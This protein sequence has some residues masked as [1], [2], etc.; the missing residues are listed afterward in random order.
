MRRIISLL[1]SLL[2]FISVY[3]QKTSTI[4]GVVKD[5]TTGEPLIGASVSYDVGKGTITELD[6][7]YKLTLDTGVYTF[8]ISFIGYVETTAKVKANRNT[9]V[10]DFTLDIKPMKEVEIVGDVAKI[11][12]TPVAFANVNAQQIKEELG[13]RDLPMLL[14]S[15]PGVYATQT[16]GGKG[17][18]RINIRGFDQKN[19]AVMV[20]GVPVNDMENGSVFWSNWEG[21]GDVTRSMQVQRGLGA[22]KLAIPSVGGTI[23]II[24]KGIES[25]PGGSI[26]QEVGSFGF[27]KTSF[28]YTTGLINKK[29]GVTVAGSH[30]TGNGYVD[31]TNFTTWSYFVKVQYIAGKHLLS[32]GGNGSPQQHQQRSFSQPMPVFDKAYAK[33]FGIDTDSSLKA[34]GFSNANHDDRGLK[35]NPFWGTLT[36]DGKTENLNEKV[37]FYHKPQ[38]SFSDNWTINDKLT[39][40]NIAYLSIGNGGGTQLFNT[41]ITRAPETGQYNLQQV[42]DNQISDKAIDKFYSSTFHK[43]SNI[44]LASNNDHKWYGLLSNIQYKMNDNFTFTGGLDVRNYQGSHY[45]TVYDLLGG[46]YFIDQ[47]NNSQPKILA[48]VAPST[49][50]RNAAYSMKTTWDKIAYYNDGLVRWFGL[51]TQAEY[52]RNNF[53][54]FVTVT[55]SETQYKRVDYF[56][57]KD[58]I[59]NGKKISQ[60]VGWGDT[61]L[62][63]GTRS[64]T[65]N[66]NNNS[67]LKKKGDTTFL[68]TKYVVNP[69]SYTMNST[70]ANTS[71]TNWRTFF[72]YTIKTGANYNFNSHFNAFLNLGY[73]SMAPR[74][75]NV[76]DNNN[77]EFFETKNQ[78]VKAIE[79]GFGTRYSGVATN[80]NLY[81]TDW[82]NKP[83]DVVK[84]FTTPDGTFYTNINGMNAI[85]KGV[86]LDFAYSPLPRLKIEGLASIGDWKYNSA[87]KVYIYDQSDVLRDSVDFSAKNVHVGN[88]AQSQF[89]LGFRYEVFKGFYIKPRFTYFGRQ[90][91]AFDPLALTINY[92][93]KGKLIKDDRDRE[94]WRVP[95]YFLLDVYT[96]YEISL[97]KIRMSITA[98]VINILNKEYIAD[99]T[100]GGSFNASSSTVFFG[101][102]RRFQ[103]GVGVYF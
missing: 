91:S 97:W 35:F 61:M 34:S 40:F 18:S 42:Y 80:L 46:N 64:I 94:S 28:G 60:A 92:D 81:Y 57:K 50:P 72:G 52:K 14:N 63:D 33:T 41:A 77:H 31:Q 36:R 89:G 67:Q 17:D 47:A 15:T 101:G 44:I 102:P 99:A 85:H 12:E 49:T 19:V 3:S 73:M 58:L 23:N 11:R 13:A 69:K 32:L 82:Q 59:I 75:N 79:M 22:S 2:C 68:G 6:G 70:E 25:K 55:V 95:D 78:F 83:L 84:S 16:G 8:T 1:V 100:N 48:P 4:K 30:S 88:A 66:Q 9:V 56:A 103:V 20:D 26:R 51:F 21:L 54:C 27:E 96:G 74:F 86:E 24:T 39:W 10:A 45:R 71:S 53:S 5:A 62:Y 65:Y 93:S 98:G 29:F 87:K 7:S 90:Y 38:F 37:N 76:F 43:S